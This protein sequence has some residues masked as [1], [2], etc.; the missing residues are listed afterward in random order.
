DTL[1]SWNGNLAYF[2]DCEIRGSVDF[3][4]SG[5]TA[6]FDHCD[7]VQ[8][9]DAGGPLAP[10]RTPKGDGYG[11][12]FPNCNLKKAVRLDVGSAQLMR[13]WRADGQA[14]YVNC[15]MDDHISARG[16]E[17]WDGRENT[18]RATEYGS[19]KPDGTAIDLSK[20]AP[21]VKVLTAEAAAQYSIVHVLGG[22][23]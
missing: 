21:W 2:H 20:R 11:L 4:Y 15:V 16:W 17:E 6:P 9:R 22:W 12:G 18:C 14:A 19:R 1:G 3:I 5:G 23:N 8:I 13:A 7:I 10:P